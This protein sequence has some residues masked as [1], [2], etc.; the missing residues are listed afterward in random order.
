MI[1]P[2]QF[3][4]PV[5]VWLKKNLKKILARDCQEWSN[6]FKSEQK[7]EEE[8]DI[9]G[10]FGVGFYSAFMVSDKVEVET[11]SIIDEDQAYLWTSEGA[12]GYIDLS[13]PTWNPMAPKS[14]YIISKKNTDDNNYDEYLEPYR[15]RS[16]V[17]KYSNY[18]R[19]PIKMVV[20]KS[21]VKEET[22][23][24]E[25]PEY[26]SYLEDD[27]LNSMVPIWRKNKNELN[28]EAYDNFYQKKRFGY[29]EPQAHSLVLKACREL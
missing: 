25:K 22:K 27:V 29:D 14:H 19:Y 5:S 16:L 7:M 18:I 13:H 8:F 11:K 9:I 1:E 21:R 6:E 24:T 17:E 12:D 15:I 2:W 23:D 4:I 26:E 20:E 3:Q 28:D 10:Q